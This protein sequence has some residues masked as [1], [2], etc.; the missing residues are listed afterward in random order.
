MNI[1]VPVL[2]TAENIQESSI[3][4]LIWT[5]STTLEIETFNF[6]SQNKMHFRLYNLT[7]SCL[8][9]NYEF[10]NKTSRSEGNLKCFEIDCNKY[11][12]KIL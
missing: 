3:S 2:Y 1:I 8:Q 4:Q 10:R 5:Q 7:S 6:L 9:Q 11:G 12:D